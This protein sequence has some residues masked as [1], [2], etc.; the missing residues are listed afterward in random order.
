MSAAAKIR[1]ASHPLVVTANRLRDG[2]VVWLAAAG[3]ADRLAE[4]QIFPPDSAP[5]ALALGRAAERAR[6]VVG[7][8]A[9][10]VAAIGGAPRPLKFRERLRATGP[11]VD[12]APRPALPLAS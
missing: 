5:D 8:Y 3:W 9:V 11:S 6:L 4:A 1:P 2:R 10:E 12:A 7:A